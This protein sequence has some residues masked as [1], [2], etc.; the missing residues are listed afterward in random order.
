MEIIKKKSNK[1]SGYAILSIILIFIQSMM[2]I[3]LFP[4]LESPDV[5]YHITK[6]FGSTNNTEMYFILLDKY[7]DFINSF[8]SG[9]L[10]FNY[11]ITG[12]REYFSMKS[13]V[14]YSHKPNIVISILQLFNVIMVFISIGIF[15]F[16]I[17]NDKKVKKNQKRFMKMTNYLYFIYPQ[18]AY[19]ITTITPDFFNIIY[20]PFFIYLIY[21]KRNLLNYFLLILIFIFCDSGIVTNII[22]LSVYLSM[23]KI[24]KIHKTTN[25]TKWVVFT[26]IILIILYIFSR[27]YLSGLFTES[28][29]VQVANQGIE[30]SG[31]L[32]TKMVNLIMSSFCFWGIGNFI[33]FPLL[34]LIY[35]YYI[36]LIFVRILRNET[37][38]D[39]KIFEFSL[40]LI[41]SIMVVVLFFGTHSHIRFYMFWIPVAIVGYQRYIKN[42]KGFKVVNYVKQA[43]ILFLHNIFLIIFYAIKIFIL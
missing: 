28:V 15:N 11:D 12:I 13:I 31:T 38:I 37:E 17:I 19:L 6:I 2:F 43:G 22:F 16:I 7:K 18:T 26:L 23:N 24:L 14:K 34:Y 1:Y 10:Q 9:A 39:N 27:R 36:V 25:K 30:R 41:F 40:A 33:T 21:T 20:Q 3:F 42:M 32:S 29:Y 8:I 35:I 5:L 4:N